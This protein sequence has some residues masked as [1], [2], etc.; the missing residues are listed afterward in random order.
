MKTPLTFL[1][2]LTFLFLYPS[3]SF[4]QTFKCEFI[5]ERFIGGKSNNYSCTMEPEVVFSYKG[6]TYPRTPQCKDTDK[7]KYE[8]YKGLIVDMESKT[9]KWNRIEGYTEYGIKEMV[10]Y[11]LEKHETTKEDL[12]KIYSETNKFNYSYEIISSYFLPETVLYTD[13]NKKV[14]RKLEQSLLVVS[15]WKVGNGENVMSLYIPENGKS[16]ITEYN[17]NMTPERFGEGSSVKIKFGTCHK[18]NN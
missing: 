8:D 7:Y 4:S 1:L 10:E 17:V 14:K 5:Q 15:T 11:G 13:E 16:I 12:L 3:I 6:Y 18:V 9:I 2:S